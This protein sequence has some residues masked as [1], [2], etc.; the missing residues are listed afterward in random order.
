MVLQSISA[1]WGHSVVR[2]VSCYDIR[3]VRRL[4]SGRLQLS[5]GV[6]RQQASMELTRLETG[7]LG[8]MAQDDHALYEVFDFVRLHHPDARSSGATA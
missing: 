5:L 1:L 6:I 8:D 4:A 2:L 3:Q 7:L